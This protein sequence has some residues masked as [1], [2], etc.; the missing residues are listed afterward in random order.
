MLGHPQIHL[1]CGSQSLGSTSVSLSALSS[2][3]V[4]LEIKPAMV[5]GAFILQPAQRTSKTL[6]DDLQ[7]TVGI[8][9]SLRREEVT[10]QVR[11]PHRSSS[12]C[13]T[14][15]FSRESFFFFLQ[16][17]FDISLCIILQAVLK[18]STRSIETVQ[19]SSGRHIFISCCPADTPK[20]FPSTKKLRLF[21]SS[22]LS[23]PS[24]LSYRE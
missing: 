19:P 10:Q 8:S 20:L 23:V 11:T 15:T 13:R 5:E 2:V 14:S 6:P 4:D 22:S 9:V 1:C 12:G 24:G 16:P 17:R 21:S 7:P 18:R 3:S